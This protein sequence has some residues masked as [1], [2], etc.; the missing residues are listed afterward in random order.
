MLDKKLGEVFLFLLSVYYYRRPRPLSP[1]P[2]K[3]S[4][5]PT[6]VK[7][8]S[9]GVSPTIFTSKTLILMFFLG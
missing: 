7:L 4:H 9:H 8:A 3:L 6:T 2:K 1:S 5:L